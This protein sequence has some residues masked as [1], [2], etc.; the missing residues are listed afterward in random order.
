MISRIGFVALGI[1]WFITAGALISKDPPQTL[2]SPEAIGQLVV[3]FVVPIGLILMGLFG[4]S[5]NRDNQGGPATSPTSG[6][7]GVP[8]GWSQLSPV[9]KGAL[10]CLGLLVAWIG[11]LTLMSLVAVLFAP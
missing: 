10:G 9:T 6:A 3:Y 11:V 7:L 4:G 8:K 2:E 5:K 1:L